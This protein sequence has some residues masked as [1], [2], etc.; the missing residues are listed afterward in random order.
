[1]KLSDIRVPGPADVWVFIEPNAASLW[2]AGFDFDL[3][4]APNFNHWG[5]LPTDRHRSGCNLSF[6]DG[7][8]APRKWKAPKE[9]RHFPEGF[10]A[11]TPITPGGD[12]EDFNWLLAGVPR[13][14]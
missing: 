5:N 13:T 2:H 10:M 8:V 14:D 9:K 7:H 12:R 3:G 6:A 11:G 1:V 4:Q